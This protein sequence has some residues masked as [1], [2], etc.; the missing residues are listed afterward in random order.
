MKKLVFVL[1]VAMIGWG[2]AKKQI[3]KAQ[4]EARQPAPAGTEEA[5]SRFDDWTSIP[6]LAKVHFGYDQSTL[7]PA[8]RRLL[9]QNAEYLK[10]NPVMNVLV[11]GHCDERGTTGYNLALGQRRA[12]A[13]KEYY[14]MLGVPAERIATI[15]YGSEKPFAPGHD[16]NAWMQNRRGETKVRNGAVSLLN[17][18]DLKE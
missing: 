1:C 9:R 6:Q 15:S 17:E 14:K 18:K 7:A 11:E 12:A 8:E 5:S 2:C 3:L 4:D 16:E 13:I 10:D